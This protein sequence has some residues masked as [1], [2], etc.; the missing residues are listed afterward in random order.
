MSIFISIC[1]QS[2]F[3]KKKCHQQGADFTKLT[4]KLARE[5]V[6]F[7]DRL[8]AELFP[9]FCRAGVAQKSFQ[10]VP[11]FPV[12]EVDVTWT[13]VLLLI[14]QSVR[15]PFVR[16]RHKGNVMFTFANSSAG[17]MGILALLREPLLLKRLTKKSRLY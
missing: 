10:H 8:V 3:L 1:P 17:V 4:L 16:G 15:L 2:F 7:I 11:N 6:A 14:V 12:E 13:A 5:C 9:L